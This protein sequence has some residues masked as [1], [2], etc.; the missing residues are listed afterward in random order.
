[1]K[2]NCVFEKARHR[3]KTRDRIKAK[4]KE[5]S[6]ILK[7]AELDG[8]IK[9]EKLSVEY[10]ILPFMEAGE[11]NRVLTHGSSIR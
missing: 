8:I 9:C 4:L 2:E 5:L 7:R 1:M 10:E 3:L 6:N 11:L